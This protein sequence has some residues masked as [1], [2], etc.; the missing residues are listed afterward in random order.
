MAFVCA[1][2]SGSRWPVPVFSVCLRASPKF[3]GAAGGEDAYLP[4]KIKKGAAYLPPKKNNPSYFRTFA[5]AWPLAGKDVSRHDDAEAAGHEWPACTAHAGAIPQPLAWCR[6]GA[7]QR[8]A[9]PLCVAEFVRLSALR[10]AGGRTALGS[11]HTAISTLQLAGDVLQARASDALVAR[12]RRLC[13]FRQR[14][15]CRLTRLE[16]C[17]FTPPRSPPSLGNTVRTRTQ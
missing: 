2:R 15:P 1:A 4:P 12:G 7:H 13:F 6:C 5:A 14:L 8:F 17:T 10:L 16:T 11:A 9:P 3:T